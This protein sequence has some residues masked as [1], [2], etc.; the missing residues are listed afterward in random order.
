MR[1]DDLPSGYDGW[2]VLDATSQDK[3]CG[4]FRIGPV[5]VLAIQERKLGKESLY[6]GEFVISEVSADI[7]F[8]RVGK[9]FT[10]GTNRH[11]S[12]AH[13]AHNEV[14]VALVTSEGDQEHPLDLTGL[15]KDVSKKPETPSTVLSVSH[16]PPPSKDCSFEVKT[17]DHASLGEEITITVTIRNKGAMMRTVD[18]RVVGTVIHYTGQPVRNF[19][20]MQFTGVISPG[21]SKLKCIPIVQTGCSH[22]NYSRNMM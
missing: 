4:R 13:V 9:N 3:Q 2:Q 6:D 7:R 8:L 18:G 21:Q 14:G 10:N 19:M 5:S 12:I 22:A 20:S 1:R 17:S 11:L 15:Y 16:F